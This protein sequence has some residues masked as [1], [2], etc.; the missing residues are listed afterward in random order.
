M[1]HLIN[2]IMKK[3]LLGLMVSIIAIIVTSC[4]FKSEEKNLCNGLVSFTAPGENKKDV[5]IG[6]KDKISDIV[7]VTPARYKEVSADERVIICR[8]SETKLE[9][10]NHQGDPIGKGVFDTFTKMPQ[11]SIYIGT[12]YKTTTYYCPLQEETITTQNTLMAIRQIFLQRK[13]GEWEI[14]DYNGNLLWK[15]PRLTEGEKYW[16]I[17]DTKA[18]TESYYFAIT[19]SKGTPA[20]ILYDDEGKEVK[21]LNASKWRITQKKLLNLKEMNKTTTYAEFESIKKF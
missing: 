3:V 14:R 11:G 18:P 12:K 5:L 16:I 7:I 6:V 21:K 2:R 9:V 8:E 4:G 17:K 20:C 10:Y 15:T 13:S 19:K 1:N